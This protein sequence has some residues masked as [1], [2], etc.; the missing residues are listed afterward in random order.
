MARC[1]KFFW[2]LRFELKDRIAYI[3]RNNLNKVI[4]VAANHELILEKEKEAKKSSFVL[5]TGVLAQN[6][7]K[8]STQQTM[9]TTNNSNRRKR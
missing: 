4:N 7:P 3:P 9:E 1:I 6:V 8:T 2:G 5:K